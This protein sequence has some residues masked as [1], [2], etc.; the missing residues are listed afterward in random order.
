[1]GN[2][3]NSP[4][5]M[6]MKRLIALDKSNLLPHYQIPF[7]MLICNPDQLTF[8]IMNIY[9]KRWAMFKMTKQE[10]T[11]TSLLDSIE[12]GDLTARHDFIKVGGTLNVPKSDFLPG[13]MLVQY[14]VEVKEI[15][16]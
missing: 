4:E 7:Q 12:M 13:N 8:P 1:V 15:N 11:M 6:S 3:I 10:K 2:N 5:G 16:I 9:L 14:S